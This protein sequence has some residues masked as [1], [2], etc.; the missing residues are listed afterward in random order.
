MAGVGNASARLGAGDGTPP[1]LIFGGYVGVGGVPGR[2]SRKILRTV[3]AVSP[4]GR[5]LFGAPYERGRIGRAP[6]RSVKPKYLLN[7]CAG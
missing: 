7:R 1:N 4:N 2:I 3:V 6:S 5:E